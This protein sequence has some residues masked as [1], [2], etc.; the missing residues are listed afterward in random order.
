LPRNPLMR[1]ARFIQFD[2]YLDSL[3]NETSYAGKPESRHTYL[4]NA[5]SQAIL[6]S[7]LL[8]EKN[9]GLQPFREEVG[10]EGLEQFRIVVKKSIEISAFQANEFPEGFIRVYDDDDNGKV[11]RLPLLQRFGPLIDRLQRCATCHYHDT[12]Q[13]ILYLDYLVTEETRRAFSN[14]FESAVDLFQCLQIL[15]ILNLYSVSDRLKTALY[16]SGSL[17]VNETVPTL[18]LGKRVLRYQI[19]FSAIIRFM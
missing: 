8:F 10:I 16:R 19:V 2:E 5:F 18:S 7:N 11:Y 15:L 4:D 1:M 13:D 3:K 9:D 12:G 17:Y 14:N 6:L